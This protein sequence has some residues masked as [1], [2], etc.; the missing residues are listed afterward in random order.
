MQA[1]VDRIQKDGNILNGDV[2]KVDAFITHQVDPVLMEEIAESF[3]Q[4]FKEAGIT[5]V[6]TIEASGIVPAVYTAQK[7]GVPMIYA[8]KSK[9][10]TMNEELLTT[11]VYSFTKQVTS[12]VSISRKF[13]SKEDKILIIDDFLANGQAAKGLIE[14]CRQANASVEGIGILIEKSFQPGRKLLE[15]IGVKVVSLARI[16]SL[17]NGKITFIEGDA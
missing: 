7:F 16:S 10:L 12:T 1:L 5:K 6:V 14:L 3:Y 13:L 11:E 17:E 8:R 9:S 4:A 15:E 2:L